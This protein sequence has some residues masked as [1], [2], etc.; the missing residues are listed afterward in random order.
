MTPK[1]QATKAKI[2]KWNYTKLKTFC[3]AKEIINKMKRQTMEW[4]KIFAN[5]ILDKG[6]I[7]K[8]CK[9]LIQLNS[10]NTNNLIKKWVEDSNKHFSKE[11][12]QMANKY[13]KRC[14]MSSGKCKSKPQ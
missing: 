10:K 2:N 12:I 13:M 6:L 7:S 4:E 14:S 9:E 8:M 1:A 11:D 3:T 5:Y